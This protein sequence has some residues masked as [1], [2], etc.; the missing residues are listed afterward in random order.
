MAYLSIQA[1]LSETVVL[2]NTCSYFAHITDYCCQVSLCVC[3]T[4]LDPNS[5]LGKSGLKLKVS[6]VAEN[7]NARQEQNDVTRHTRKKH[8]AQQRSKETRQQSW[9][10]ETPGTQLNETRGLNMR[11]RTIRLKQ[12]VETETFIHCIC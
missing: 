12:E 6:F 10:C 9:R 1:A 5:G 2:C 8:T 11:R 7:H 4:A 3:Q